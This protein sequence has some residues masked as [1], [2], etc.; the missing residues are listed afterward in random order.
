MTYFD[1]RIP[2]L[3]MTVIAADGQHVKPVETDE[4]QIAVAETYD[5]L[6]TLPDERAYTMFAETIDRS[7]YAR[8][9]VPEKHSRIAIVCSKTVRIGITATPAFRSSLGTSVQ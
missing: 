3:P 5:V 9:S 7:G 4:I 8:G 1:F 6:V 2:G